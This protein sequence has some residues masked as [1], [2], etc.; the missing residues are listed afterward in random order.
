[1]ALP[2]NRYRWRV[3]MA[4]LREAA[5]DLDGAVELLDEADRLYVGDFSPRVRPVP[6]VRARVRIR[7]GRLDDVRGW[8]RREGV[9]ASDDL[10]YLREY[11]HVTLARALL[12]EFRTDRDPT[13][14]DDADRL[15]ARLLEAAEAGDRLSTAIEVLVLQA[16]SRWLRGDGAGASEALDRALVLAE[17]EGHIRVFLDEGR[18]MAELLRAV[19]A[20]GSSTPGFVRTLLAAQGD[21]PAGPSRR[22]PG[23]LVEP[24]SEREREVLRLLATDLSGPE[25]ARRLVLSLNT[26]RTHTKNVYAKL[27]V[28]SRRAAVRR[29]EELD[30]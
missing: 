30:L 24:L 8:A 2:Q 15:L 22:A 3:A 17:P 28:N 25:I 18:P 12:E 7:Q 29:A 13:V 21:E 5:G 1:M 19:A 27:G 11:E 10:G 6:A 14:L 20:A 16:L 26:V 9:A 4:R 23:R